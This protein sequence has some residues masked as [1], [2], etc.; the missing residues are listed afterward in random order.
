M[1]GSAPGRGVIRAWF[2][3]REIHSFQEPSG[4]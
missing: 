2:G 3:E 1:I 4:T